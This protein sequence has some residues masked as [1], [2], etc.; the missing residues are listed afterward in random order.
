M[1]RAVQARKQ[2][3]AAL[4]FAGIATFVLMGVL[5]LRPSGEP[6]PAGLLNTAVNQLAEASSYNL[7][8]EEKAPRYSLL[9]QGAVEDKDTLTGLLPGYE[10]EIIC[11]G[12][13]LL[14]RK[15]GEMEWDTEAASELQG[16]AG[17]LTNPVAV[18]QSVDLSLAAAGQDI[19]LAGDS[20]RTV[21]LE[22]TGEKM[23]IAHLFPDI[24]MNMVQ[25]ANLGVAL[26]EPGLT[27]KQMR[28]LVEFLDGGALERVYH[29]GSSR[30]EL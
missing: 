5:I 14:V 18:L 6:S 28:V 4:A 2:T 15:A 16:L 21:Y 13:E 7:V 30:E 29:V 11:R 20:C 22:I 3:Q 8:I 10:L 26:A 9:F 17:F 25:R 19:E 24:E 12:E 27:V 1:S 23:L